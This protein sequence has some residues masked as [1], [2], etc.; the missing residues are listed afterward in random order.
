MTPTDRIRVRTVEN[1]VRLIREHL[2][3]MQRDPQG[4]EY[5]PWKREVDALWKRT[6]AEINRMSPIPQQAALESVKELWMTYINHYDVIG[7]ASVPG[8]VG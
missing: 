8:L 6:F 3:A 1:H 4:L 2:E 5:D 7:R